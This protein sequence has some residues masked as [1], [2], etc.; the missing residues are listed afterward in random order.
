[1]RI[2]EP[3]NPKADR[4]HLGQRGKHGSLA[5]RDANIIPLIDVVFI[6]ILYFMLAGSLEPT[7]AEAVKPP[8]SASI[9]APPTEVPMVIIGKDG[10]LLYEDTGQ[11]DAGLALVLNNG[12]HP[13]PQLILQ[14]DADADA[15]RVA[16]VVAIIGKAGV[17]ELSLLTRPQQAK[18]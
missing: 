10:K 17:G 16:D 7:L 12:G 8:Q 2:I 18:P 3:P 9:A 14:A 13:P 4:H 11:D 1:M 15:G 6:L 5:E